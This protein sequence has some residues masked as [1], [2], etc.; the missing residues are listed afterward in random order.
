V[1]KESLKVLKKIVHISSAMDC[2]RMLSD[3]LTGTKKKMYKCSI[4]T[5]DKSNDIGAEMETSLR[6]P[7]FWLALQ[8]GS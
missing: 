2:G 1:E 7:L 4:L 5:E 8:S 6:K 3:R